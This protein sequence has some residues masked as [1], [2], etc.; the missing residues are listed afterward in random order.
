M[1]NNHKYAQINNVPA[2]VHS[3]SPFSLFFLCFVRLFLHLPFYT[4][5]FYKIAAKTRYNTRVSKKI[6]SVCHRFSA[7]TSTDCLT[8]LETSHTNVVAKATL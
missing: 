1:K 5:F 6:S 8:N 3:F 7:L 2:Y 4:L